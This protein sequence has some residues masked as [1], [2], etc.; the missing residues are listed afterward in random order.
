ML[1]IIGDMV[2]VPSETYLFADKATRFEKLSEPQSVLV[3]G[4]G[5]QHY[6]VLMLG[7]PWWVRKRD[8]YTV[9]KEV[10]DDRQAS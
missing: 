3:I 1:P 8:V 9:Q 10:T 4:E 5:H 6:Q 2:Y 7:N